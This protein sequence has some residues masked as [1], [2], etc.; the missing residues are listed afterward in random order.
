MVPGVIIIAASLCLTVFR[1]YKDKFNAI[2]SILLTLFA[3]NAFFI[4]YIPSAQNKGV[5]R[6]LYI[7]IFTI[8]SIP[9]LYLGTYV[10]YIVVTRIRV[11]Q[12][13][14]FRA[15]HRQ[16]NE[17]DTIADRILNPE[18]YNEDPIRMEPW[19]Q[20]TADSSQDYILSFN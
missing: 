4:G 5:I 12:K 11:L 2:D 1:P 16:I 9:L 13:C 18:I 17:N 8:T 14:S 19:E 7:S 10:T 3:I 6:A 15:A 20:E